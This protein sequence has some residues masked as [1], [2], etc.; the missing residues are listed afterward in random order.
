MKL[1]NTKLALL[2]IAVIFILSISSLSAVKRKKFASALKKTH[3]HK[4]EGGKPITL[5]LGAQNLVKKEDKL[6]TTGEKLDSTTKENTEVIS[7]SGA[8]SGESF[9][10]F[11]HRRHNEK[12]N[13][14]NLTVEDPLKPKLTKAERRRYKK[15]RHY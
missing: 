2:L 8:E 14:D 7:L 10:D 11:M 13:Q 12:P 5:D 6:L 15:R 3:R 1:S 9:D 4:R